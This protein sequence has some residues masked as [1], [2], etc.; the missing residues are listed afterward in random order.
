MELITPTNQDVQASPIPRFR[1]Q[2][3]SAETIYELQIATDI[4]FTNIIETVTDL[5]TNFYQNITLDVLTDYFWR[6]RGSNLCGDGNWSEVFTFKTADIQCLETPCND[7]PV[8]LPEEDVSTTVSTIEISEPGLVTDLNVTSLDIY[9]SWVGDLIVTLES[10]SGKRVTLFDQP[11][12]P[13]SNFGCPEDN[14]LLGFDDEALETYETLDAT[15][16]EGSMA[17]SGIFQPFES[18]K[19]FRGEAAAGIWKLTIYDMADGDGGTLNGWNLD[20][21]STIIPDLSI[22]SSISSPIFCAGENVTFQIILGTGY[23]STGIDLSANG[24]PDGATVIFSQNNVL[25]GATVDVTIQGLNNVGTFPILF[26]A[27]DGDNTF[28]SEISI[29]IEGP[30]DEP[31]LMFPLNTQTGIPLTPTLFW[32]ESQNAS[33]YHVEIAE[34]NAFNN[35]ISSN[36]QVD[37]EYNSPELN[38]NQVYFWRVTAI[39]D[40][41]FTVSP[42]FTFTTDVIN[43]VKTLSNDEVSI[44]PNPTTG[45]LNVR[46]TQ[47]LQNNVVIELF[48]A[49]GQL[50]QQFVS[51]AIGNEIEVDLTNFSD[52]VYLLRIVNKDAVLS[53]K[54]VLQK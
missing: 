40:C 37:L 1:W 5:D 6:V 44:F 39:N 7:I 48:S 50:A 10:P 47:A 35:V 22:T 27:N 26:F 31:H 4:N 41:G 53:R 29:Q 9:H 11:G 36:I 49:N 16:N 21:C 17:I 38:D 15:C 43:A 28:N 23:N 25:P 24:Y 51:N 8:L 46:F 13:E 33:E 14:L 32:I 19:L 54:I 45:K 42:V 2:A 20:I 34:D 18:L 3:D 30:P 12:V 52:G